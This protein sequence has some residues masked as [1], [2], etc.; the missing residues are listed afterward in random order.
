MIVNKKRRFAI[1]VCTILVVLSFALSLSASAYSVDPADGWFKLDLTNASYLTGTNTV[2]TPYLRFKNVFTPNIVTPQSTTELY[3]V[4]LMSKYS[5][6]NEVDGTGG[7]LYYTYAPVTVSSYMKLPEHSEDAPVMYFPSAVV[8]P[9]A[10]AQNA[11]VSSDMYEYNFKFNGGI[12]AHCRFA[13]SVSTDGKDLTMLYNPA[14]FSTAEAFLGAYNNQTNF[15]KFQDNEMAIILLHAKNPG[16]DLDYN[17]GYNKGYS[18]G[19]NVG[20]DTGSDSVNTPIG[21]LFGGVNSVLSVKLF[22]DVT[23]GLIVYAA[24]G[25]G[26]LFVVMKMFS[27]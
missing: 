24:L 21:I 2:G 1:V 18:D 25:L 16:L 11:G 14:F 20:F 27:K 9:T 22:G 6:W 5:E 26:A 13:I 19:Y 15:G 23:L 17:D 7:P 4:V 8:V 10:E 3:E 12:Y